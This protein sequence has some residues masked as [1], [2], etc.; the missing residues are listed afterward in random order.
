MSTSIKTSALAVL[1][2][3]GLSAVLCV[4]NARADGAFQLKSSDGNFSGNLNGRLE[5]DGYYDNNDKGSRIGSGVAGSDSSDSF[6]FR[7]AWLTLAGNVYSFDYHIDY[8]FVANILQR[9]WLSHEVLPHGTL[10]IGQD[11]PWA[12][13]D[14]IA[15][16]TDTP[17]LERNIASSSGVNSA[18]TYTN[19]LYYA[20]HNR[21]FTEEDNLWFGL[22]GSALHKQSGGVDT[23]TQGTAFNARVAYAPIVAKDRWL[24]FGL[25]FINANA[26]AGSTTAG[27]NALLASYVYGNHFDSDEKLTLANYPVSSTGTKPHANTLGGEL[28]AAYG[29]A[30]LQAE[31][32]NAKFREAGEPDNT[33]KAYSVTGA[34]T[35]TGET[36]P[37]KPEDATY[38]GITPIHAY[39]AWELAVRY[40]KARN[41]GNSGVF[42]GL[43][44]PGA[45]A[46]LATLDQ[47][48]LISA[49]VNYYPNAHVRFML[50]YEHGKADLGNAGTDSPNT[51]AARAQLVF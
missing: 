15:S 23:S 46:S 26:A 30:Y 27:T 17:F 38:R 1:V 6:R 51:V 43:A 5:F 11:K 8:D 50:D 37:Y 44:L 10:Y 31:Y 29:P 7:R 28:A 35:L 22:S 2:S 34:F 21:L 25:S 4:D 20:W 48:T 14:E 36:R 39:G 13:L 18:A 32:D 24:H 45:K 33:V 41:D 9:A 3:V 47:V 16:D 12:S 19:G 42:T 40:E 49:G